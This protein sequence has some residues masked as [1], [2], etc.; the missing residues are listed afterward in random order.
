MTDWKFNEV[1]SRASRLRRRVIECLDD[2]RFPARI[3]DRR[4]KRGGIK[5]SN[6]WA[7]VVHIL[8][9]D[10]W[11]LYGRFLPWQC[12][13]LRSDPDGIR[14]GLM[15]VGEVECE[16]TWGTTDQVFR[17]EEPGCR[18]S[19]YLVQIY[20]SHALESVHTLIHELAHVLD[21]RQVLTGPQAHD[22]KW[23]EI[24]TEL[25]IEYVKGCRP[26]ILQNVGLTEVVEYEYA[27]VIRENMGGV[28]IQSPFTN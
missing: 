4:L 13:H 10:I 11:S 23:V 3:Y 15:I 20:T 27:F 18:G 19:L 9:R 14:A 28:S 5:Q 12:E 21:S 7:Q 8:M 1:E 16:T 22:D 17:C 26:K 24:C 25:W 2:A 6:L